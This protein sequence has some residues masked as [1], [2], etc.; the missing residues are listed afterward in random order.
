MRRFEAVSVVVLA[1]ALLAGI[2]PGPI[3]SMPLDQMAI[4]RLLPRLPL[5]RAEV[6][7]PPYTLYL[8]LALGLPPTLS[9]TPQ[10]SS[11]FGIEPTTSVS[12]GNTLGRI[13]DL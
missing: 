7:G 13:V 11:P 8:P 6:A 1:F 10:P 5:G 12:L 9:P 2:L 3:A 4:D